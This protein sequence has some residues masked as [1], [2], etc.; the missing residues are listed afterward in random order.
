MEHIAYYPLRKELDMQRK[1][2]LVKA[3]LEY[4]EQNQVNDIPLSASSIAIAGYD[5]EEIYHI[6]RLLDE[7]ELILVYANDMN[8]LN[9]LPSCFMGSVNIFRLTNAGHDFL[10]NSRHKP[11]LWEAAKKVAG[12]SSLSV[13][14]KIL[15][16]LVVGSINVTL[17]SM[18]IP[19]IIV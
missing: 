7:N 11:E 16:K 1:M 2:D 17:Q 13:F 10:D 18:G 4:I 3:V 12:D 14:S 6:I 9:K 8:R 19:P 5:K 15:E